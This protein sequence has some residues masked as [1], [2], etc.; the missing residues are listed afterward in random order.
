MSQFGV[1]SHAAPLVASRLGLENEPLWQHL[2]GVDF[3]T[4]FHPCFNTMLRQS[5]LACSTRDNQCLLAPLSLWVIQVC[6]RLSAPAQVETATG[7][8]VPALSSHF[9]AAAF[10][11][12]LMVAFLRPG[13]RVVLPEVL[14]C[15]GLKQQFG[16]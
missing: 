14:N 3:S 4:C 1:N 11:A 16:V 8:A 7:I 9:R 6:E 13:S 2:A 12:L 10:L 5:H 15:W